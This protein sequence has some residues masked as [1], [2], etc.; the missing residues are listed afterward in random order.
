MSLASEAEHIRQAEHNERFLESFD[1]PTTPFLDWATTAIFYTAVHYVRAVAAHHRVT[2]ISRHG[3]VDKLFA[4]LPILR[5]N[6]GV[7]DDY[8]QL[9]DDSRDA[10]YDMRR[11]TLREVVELRDE[12]LSRIRGFV[13]LYLSV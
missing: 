6:P 7:Y 2:N 1:L 8:R 4:T 5:Q 11:L 10:R 3:E 13:R 9:K 12:E